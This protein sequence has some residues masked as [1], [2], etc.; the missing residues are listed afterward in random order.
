[1]GKPLILVSS[2][3]YA[4]KGKDLLM[5]HGISSYLQRI[6]R[7]QLQGGCGYGLYVPRNMD[8]AESIL[9]EAG[10]KVLGVLDGEGL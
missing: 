7:A 8:R 4:M 10:I 3:T 1:M 2:I 9:R 5:N 6:P